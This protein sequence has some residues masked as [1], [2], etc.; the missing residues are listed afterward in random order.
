MGD[1]KVRDF[2]SNGVRFLNK[3]DIDFLLGGQKPQF[4][5]R[6]ATAREVLLQE[7]DLEFGRARGPAAI[8]VILSA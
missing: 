7:C 4:V 3:G 1:S 6:C 2:V 5:V 8:L